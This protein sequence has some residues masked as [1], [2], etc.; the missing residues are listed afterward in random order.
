MTNIDSRMI[1][2]HEVNLKKNNKIKNVCTHIYV[3]MYVYV[4]VY[5][6][7]YVLLLLFHSAIADY[8]LIN[9]DKYWERHI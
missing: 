4:C 7:I 6:C 9:L 3:C 2:N 5:I 1:E 8:H